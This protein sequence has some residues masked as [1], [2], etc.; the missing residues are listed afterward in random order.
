MNYL[1]G[2][3]IGTSGTKTVLFDIEGNT[4]SSALKEYPMEQPHIGWAE[5]NPED[6]WD[7]TYNTIKQVIV[8]SGVDPK[9]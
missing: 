4:I 5:Q 2:V 1:I 6:W 7:A 9:I 3:D 8:K